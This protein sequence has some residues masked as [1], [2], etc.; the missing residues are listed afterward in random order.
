MA[1]TISTVG[2]SELPRELRRYVMSVEVTLIMLNHGYDGVEVARR[3]YRD[4]QHD[5]IK[6]GIFLTPI[7]R[8]EELVRLIQ[9]KPIYGGQEHPYK[10]VPKI[11]RVPGSRR[12][13][14]DQI[15]RVWDID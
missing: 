3:E 7:G 13:W 8:P 6:E 12:S 5:E 2:F 1:F 4:I 9:K 14:Y 15:I 11:I 10:A